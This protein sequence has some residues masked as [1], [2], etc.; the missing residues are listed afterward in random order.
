MALWCCDGDK[1]APQSST[2]LRVVELRSTTLQICWRLTSSV[3]VN[4]SETP[5]PGEELPDLVAG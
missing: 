2:K 1:L 3:V 4:P 5:G